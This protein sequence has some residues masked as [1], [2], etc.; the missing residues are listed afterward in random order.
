MRTLEVAN[1]SLGSFLFFELS[2]VSMNLALNGY[3]MF[4]VYTLFTTGISQLIW[5][6]IFCYWI[7]LDCLMV[8]I[9]C[10]LKYVIEQVL[11]IHFIHIFPQ[12]AFLGQCFSLF[13]GTLFWQS[14]KLV[15]WATSPWLDN[16]LFAQKLKQRSKFKNCR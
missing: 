12:Q 4:T 13:L 6:E 5:F 14:W 1:K 8:V 7:M 15:K 10:N 16:L 3:F 9:I 11:F 2:E